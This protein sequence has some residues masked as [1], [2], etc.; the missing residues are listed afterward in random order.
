MEDSPVLT[1]KT[2]IS[3]YFGKCVP[4]ILYLI[5]AIAFAVIGL[6][7]ATYYGNLKT[8]IMSF[9][10]AL[11]WVFV[12]SVILNFVCNIDRNVYKHGEL[13]VWVIVLVLLTLQI[14]AHTSFTVITY[15]NNN[16][17]LI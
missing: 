14:S 6:I 10:S 5:F 1:R 12:V 16:Q 13:T 17:V 4:V 2:D 7:Y 15:K 11:F 9:L 3:G 8:G